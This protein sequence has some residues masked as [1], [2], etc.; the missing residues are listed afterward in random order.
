MKILRAFEF[1]AAVMII[2]GIVGSLGKVAVDQVVAVAT[3]PATATV[4]VT[5]PTQEEL[6]AYLKNTKRSVQMVE[7]KMK[8]DMEAKARGER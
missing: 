5:A 2:I 3:R 8:A 4:M 1:I 6:E 7:D